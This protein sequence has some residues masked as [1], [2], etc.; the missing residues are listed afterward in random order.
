MLDDL[1]ERVFRPELVGQDPLR[2]ECAGCGSSIA[3][4]NSRCRPS[5]WSTSLDEFL[6]VA[7][8]R[9]VL[10][11]RGIKLHA[12]GDARRDAASAWHRTTVR[13]AS[14]CW[15]PSSS[16]V[17]SPTPDTWYEEPMREFS[18]ALPA[19][20]PGGRCPAAHRRDVPQRPH[21]CGDF[22]AARAATFAVRTGT[23]L[24][25]GITVAMRIAHL[26][27]G[28]RLRAALHGSD[29]PNLTCA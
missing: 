24:P 26:A 5:V 2:R 29:M 25:G 3:S 23:T 11:Y 19:P 22:V 13:R 6:D 4:R 8:Q 15:T 28:Y 16:A 1:V 17:R 10:G 27:D 18:V 20:R 9:L 14:T 12:W 21:N 7:D